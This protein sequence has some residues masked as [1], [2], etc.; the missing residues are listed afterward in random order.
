M[1]IPQLRLVTTSNSSRVSRPL[2]MGICV[3]NQRYI[4]AGA[5]VTTQSDAASLPLAPSRHQPKRQNLP[6][7]PYL[8][9]VGRSHTP[10]MEYR[11]A[12]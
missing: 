11:I 9:L 5:I 10:E 1:A 2:A 4:A 7:Q 3:P 12:Q 6:P 8:R